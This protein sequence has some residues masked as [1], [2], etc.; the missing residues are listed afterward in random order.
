MRL[1]ALKL[2][3][4]AAVLALLAVAAPAAAT[5]AP[6]VPSATAAT[7]ATTGDNSERLKGLPISKTPG[8]LDRVA[9]SIAPDQFDPIQ[10]GDRLRVS[11]EV[12]VSTTCV[13]PGPRCV[14]THYEI[15]PKVTARVVLSPGP[16]ASDGFLPLSDSRTQLCKQRRPNRNHHC[17]IALPNTE[18]TISDLAALPCPPEACYVNLIVGATNP[19]AKR[20]NKVVLGGDQPDGSVEQDKGRLNVVQAHPTVPLPQTSQTSTLVEPSLP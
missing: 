8:K 14:G 15:N 4:P 13:E 1:A 5:K 19:K 6:V 20:G 7:Y 11:G 12:Q 9:M 10:V 3:V 18:T 16:L 2:V 17:T